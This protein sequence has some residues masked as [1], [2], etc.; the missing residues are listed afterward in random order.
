MKFR[1][2]VEAIRIYVDDNYR[3]GA[4]QA[5][6][7]IEAAA[8]DP[9]GLL[10]EAVKTLQKLR[11]AVGGMESRGVLISFSRSSDPGTLLALDIC[12][13]VLGG[14]KGGEQGSLLGDQGDLI[15]EIRILQII[16][17]G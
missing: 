13:K 7:L 16:P 4:Y 12:T 1:I 2:L 15:Q 11:T 3:M 8:E 6:L 10:S 9:F 17:I 5:L 14:V